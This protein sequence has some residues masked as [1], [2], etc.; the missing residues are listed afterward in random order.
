MHRGPEDV[1]ELADPEGLVEETAYT[2]T[3]NNSSNIDI[4]GGEA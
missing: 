1:S 2:G 3:K 4:I